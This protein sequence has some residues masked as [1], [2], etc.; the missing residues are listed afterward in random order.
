MTFSE[1]NALFKVGIVICTISTLLI[2]AVSF[3][4]VPSYQ[5]IN[6]NFSRPAGFL[7]AFIS[8]I[9]DFDYLAVHVSV[10]LAVLFSING[11][12][13]IHYF[14]EQTSA[15]EILYIAFFTISFSFE[16]I[17]LILPL[18]FIFN[19]PSLYMLLTSRLLLFTRY[20][21]IFSLFAA[22][23]CAA[24]LEAQKASIVIL[25]IIIAALIITF[26]VPI[27]TQN[28]DTSFNIVNGYISMFRLIET[29]A[30]ITTILS[31]L[32][33]VN[34]RGSKDYAY[35]GLGV[36]IALIGRNLLIS[37]DNWVFSIL[38]VLLLSAGTWFIC[39]KLH[40]IHLWL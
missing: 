36:L 4:V 18:H 9:L 2:L 23:I 10:I 12:V 30:F 35:I 16:I 39:L 13:L 34:V 33:A 38:G 37:A 5:T 25:V 32:I 3:L 40:T 7:H 14:F 11:I 20:F 26:S 21:G 1:R 29:I 15:P 22:G 27:D 24:G 19:I 6:E 8:R 31:F 17:R 28:W